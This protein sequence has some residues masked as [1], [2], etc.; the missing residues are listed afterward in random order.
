MKNIV[1]FCSVVAAT[2]GTAIAGLSPSAYTGPSLN[3]DYQS[4]QGGAPYFVAPGLGGAG[5]F[6]IAMTGGVESALGSTAAVGSGLATGADV[7]AESSATDNGGGN[8]DI[9]V[10]I[11]TADGSDLAPAGFT[12]GGLPADTLGFFMGLNAGGSVCDLGD[13]MHVTSA[14]IELFDPAGP[15]GGPFDISGF[16]N[17]S[18]PAGWDGSA[19]VV[20]GAG[21]AGSGV[22]MMTLLVNVDVVPAPS[23]LAALAF[24]GLVASRRRRS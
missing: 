11:F 18:D 1:T 3:A 6:A 9:M 15:A 19:G 14:T 21:S 5:G 24:G 17:F 20:F 12:V 22:N 10:S 23:G 8:W 2:A 4:T 13:T 16:A 7:I